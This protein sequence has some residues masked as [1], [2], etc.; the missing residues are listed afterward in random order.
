MF[1]WSIEVGWDE[2]WFQGV[3]N[4]QSEALFYEIMSHLPNDDESHGDGNAGE[5][6]QP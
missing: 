1:N 6:H 3:K 4:M 5:S 2:F